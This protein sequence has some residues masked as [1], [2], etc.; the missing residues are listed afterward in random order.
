MICISKSEIYIKMD[1]FNINII[2]SF[3]TILWKNL[4]LSCTSAL[5]RFNYRYTVHTGHARDLSFLVVRPFP[6]KLSRNLYKLTLHLNSFRYF[7]MNQK[8][9]VWYIYLLK[10]Q[11]T[12]ENV[13][14]TFYSVEL[15]I[16]LSFLEKM[17]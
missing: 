9:P 6:A 15:L 7:D 16:F 13:A 5:S 1:N 2:F 4:K 12:E 8:F 14:T 17:F 3:C 10:L 11:V